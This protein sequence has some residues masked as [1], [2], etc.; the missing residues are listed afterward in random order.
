MQ[1][2]RLA[3]LTDPQRACLRKVAQG[4]QY[5]EIARDL[6]IT[7]G[8][9]N[10]RLKAAMRTLE[11]NSRFDAARLLAK[12]EGA[13]AYQPPAPQPL[14]DQSWGLAGALPDAP[15]VTYT[16]QA[17]SQRQPEPVKVV[18]ER[19]AVFE[20]VYLTPSTGSRLKLPIPTDGRPTNDLD[21]WQRIAWIFAVAIGA[22]L[23]AGIL[24]T[25]VIT[26]LEA[27]SKVV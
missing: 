25:F 6:G 15:S 9:V 26:G 16:N 27:L 18:Q 21:S 3:K 11:L 22:A 4:F 14:V 23:A 17:G 7:P 20:P 19:Q 2:D 12:Y 24:L 5:K 8:A 10:E 1:D 13:A